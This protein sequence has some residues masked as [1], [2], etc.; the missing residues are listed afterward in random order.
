M[1]DPGGGD[2]G[3]MRDLNDASLKKN[4]AALQAGAA[5][6]HSEVGCKQKHKSLDCTVIHT[7]DCI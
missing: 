2:G 6:S 5:G 4:E 3:T 1:A 7:L